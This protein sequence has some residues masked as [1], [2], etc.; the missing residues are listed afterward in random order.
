LRAERNLPKSPRKKTEIVTALAE[1]F[2]LRIKPIINAN[3]G[4]P[5]IELSEAQIKMAFRF[6]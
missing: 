6:P 5:K 3:L 2:Q 4:R 1:K